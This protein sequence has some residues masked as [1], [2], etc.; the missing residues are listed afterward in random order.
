MF[1]SS[2]TTGSFSRRAQLCEVSYRPTQYLSANK[3]TV[4]FKGHVAFKM[5]NPQ[6]PTKWGLCICTSM[7]L[8]IPKRVCLWLDP[9]LWVNNY[10]NLMH[11]GL[12]LTSRIVLELISKVQNVTNENVCHLLTDR[13]YI[14]MGLAQELLKRKVHLIGT[15]Q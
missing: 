2:S 7:Y 15:I 8:Q 13:F 5:Y 14:N 9:L 6:K 3:S 11:S 12:N 1:L 10:K 4:N